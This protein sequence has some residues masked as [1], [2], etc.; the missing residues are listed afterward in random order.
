MSVVTN[1]LPTRSKGNRRGGEKKL[2]T[3]GKDKIEFGSKKSVM[4]SWTNAYDVVDKR[5]KQAQGNIDLSK[6][7]VGASIGGAHRSRLRRMQILWPGHNYMGPGNPLENGEPT[8]NADKAARIH[9][10]AYAHAWT[11]EDIK[12]ADN[13]AKRQFLEHPTEISSVVGYSGIAIKNFVEKV[14]GTLYP[15]ISSVNKTARARSVMAGIHKK[16]KWNASRS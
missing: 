15:N 6:H 14:T 7:K 8:T 5:F 10:Y 4:E 12:H 3:R 9:D 13:E 11:E 1:T 16:N 2:A